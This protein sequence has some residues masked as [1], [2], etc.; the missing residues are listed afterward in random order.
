MT[1]RPRPRRAEAMPA[2]AICEMAFVVQEPNVI[3]WR[4]VNSNT[5]TPR[6]SLGNW[7]RAA[8]MLDPADRAG[9][10]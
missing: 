1:P 5:S 3:I 7:Y 10:G 4:W 9:A 2:S 8:A 6:S